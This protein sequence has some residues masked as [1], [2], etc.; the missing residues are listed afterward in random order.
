LWTDNCEFRKWPW[1]ISWPIPASTESNWGK[2]WEISR[3]DNRAPDLDS[4]RRPLSIF[5]STGLNF[6]DIE[7][8]L[9]GFE[10]RCRQRIFL[11]TVPDTVCR[12]PSLTVKW[13]LR[14]CHVPGSYR[15]YPERDFRGGTAPYSGQRPFD[16]LPNISLS[17]TIDLLSDITLSV[18][19]TN[20]KT[21]K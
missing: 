20:G 21:K 9:L 15:G 11:F 16:I 6:A 4:N 2:S 5:Q 13:C 10:S 1:L 8:E 3:Q 12:I 14:I 18:K 7:S 17:F 19:M